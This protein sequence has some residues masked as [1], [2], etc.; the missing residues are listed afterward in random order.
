MPLLAAEK[1]ALLD[2]APSLIS[3][4]MKAAI[5]FGGSMPKLSSVTRATISLSVPL[6]GGEAIS[7]VYRPS[8][9]T[10]GLLKRLQGLQAHIES[11]QTA[12]LP[13]ELPRLMATLLTS[14]DLTTD[15]EEPIP[16]T[17]EHLADI[18]LSILLHVMT[19]VADS[20]A[21]TVAG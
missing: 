16:T 17:A 14:W 15:D 8:V 2:A 1:V 13:D 5:V 3:A 11:E 6:G 18:P 19:A 20:A 4:D 9:L 21:A 7:V 12:S 10:P